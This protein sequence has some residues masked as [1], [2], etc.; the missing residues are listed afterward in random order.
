VTAGVTALRLHKPPA[1]TV[2]ALL[3]VSEGQLRTPEKLSAGALRTH[4]QELTFTRAHLGDLVRHNPKMF[5]GAAKDVDG[6]VE[7]LR[8]QITM[9]IAASDLIGE[10][11]APRTAHI[12]IGYTGSN[13]QRTWEVTNLLADLLI[14]SALERQRAAVLRQKAG[15]ESVES[16]AQQEGDRSVATSSAAAER[17]R[18]TQA[19]AAAARFGVRAAE[20]QQT[21][22]FELVDPGQV[23]T[24]VTRSE[25]AG[26]ATVTFAILLLVAS[27]LAGAFDPRLLDAD[28]LAHIGIPLVGRLP[29]LPPP[30]EPGVRTSTK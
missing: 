8:E 16:A 20:E 6:T 30:P 7:E 25:Q 10:S 9:Q 18:T 21:L 2:T 5:P 24:A 23:P 12:T 28:D 4:L 22:R 14:D 29:P 19:A 26:D 13:P 3:R 17:I 11:D 15:A 27:L 1:Y